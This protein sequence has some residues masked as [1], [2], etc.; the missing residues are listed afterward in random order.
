MLTLMIVSLLMVIVLSF[1][2]TVR[3]SLR[4][5]AL[6]MDRKMA[7][8]NARLGAELAMARLQEMMGA[9]TR[10]SAAA[11]QFRSD[12]NSVYQPG[13]SRHTGAK[14]WTG[15]W[16]SLSFTEND[17]R[18]KTFLG[19]L[20]SDPDPA[21]LEDVTV[22]ASDPGSLMM[23]GP[24]SVSREEDEVYVRAVPVQGTATDQY[25]YWV[26]DEGVKAR[27]NL[28][29]PFRGTTDFTERQY[30]MRAAQRH[31][32]ELFTY[33]P[34]GLL[35]LSQ[36]GWY[37]LDNE[38]FADMRERMAGAAQLPLLGWSPESRDAFRS[39][40]GLRFHDVSLVSKGL[41]TNTARGGLRKDLSLAF[42]MPIEEFLAH[43]T[44][45]SASP[46]S[47][48]PVY[49]PPGF[50]ASEQ[51]TPLFRITDFSSFGFDPENSPTGA[52]QNPP[53]N[54]APVLRGPSWQILRNYHRSYKQSDPDRARYDLD[55]VSYRNIGGRLVAQGRSL[56]PNPETLGWMRRYGQDASVWTHAE[57]FGPNTGPKYTT[58]R[59]LEQPIHPGVSPLVTRVQIVFSVRTEPEIV[60]G[61]PTGNFVADVYM[62]PLVTIWNPYNVPLATGE[63]Y[64]QPLQLS[65][66]F[67]DLFMVMQVQGGTTEYKRLKNLFEDATG[68]TGAYDGNAHEAFQLTLDQPGGLVLE[69]GEVVIFSGVDQEVRYQRNAGTL[70]HTD[71]SGVN[72]DLRPDIT[73]NLNTNSGIRFENPWGISLL[74]DARI[75]FRT[76]NVYDPGVPGRDP[77]WT[78][79]IQVAGVNRT[80]IVQEPF[81]GSFD[82][83][84]VVMSTPFS[85]Y[86]PVQDSSI[87]GVKRPF[88]LYDA[89]L[90]AENS[91]NPVNL[92][93]Q[94]NL[95]S[96]SMEQG[97]TTNMESNWFAPAMRV[98]DLWGGQPAQV[99]GWNGLF[100]QYV[101]NDGRSSYW[102]GASNAAGGSKRVTLFEL[103]R[104]PPMSI[105]SL[106]HAQVTF[107]VDEPSLAIGNSLVPFMV[108]PDEK[109]SLQQLNT[110]S[111]GNVNTAY[112]NLMLRWKDARTPIRD[113]WTMT[114]TDWSY[115]LNEVLWDDY[116]FSSLTPDPSTGAETWERYDAFVAGNP[117]P[118][119]TLQPFK[120]PGENMADVRARLFSGTDIRRNA[121]ERFAANLIQEGTFNVNSTS[122]EAWRA[123]LSSTRNLILNLQDQS[124][125]REL[126]GTA[127]S[128]TALPFDAENDRWHGFRNLSDAQIDAL[129]KEIVDQVRIRGPFLNLSDFINRRLDPSPHATQRSGALQSAIDALDLNQSFTRSLQDGGL[130]LS[131]LN[132]WVRDRVDLDSMVAQN[133][134]GYFQQAD[135]LTL[136]GPILSARSDTFTVRAY[137][138]HA[139]AKAWCELT[140]QR[141]PGYVDD[142]NQPWDAV[143]GLTAVNQAFGRR[144]EVTSFRWLNKEDL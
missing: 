101:S 65:F 129:A 106:Q 55:P 27:F 142:S 87:N 104:L 127:F 11:D 37:P 86:Y 35:P 62:D 18:N 2:V 97:N 117:L 9:D 100:S 141:L 31:A 63:N 118:N 56:Y 108:R 40:L 42:E 39:M 51:I 38:V 144:F 143:S 137:G 76:M 30:S 19:W 110:R 139:G 125:P 10:V 24:G 130:Q 128:R 95:R 25:G 54:L 91:E 23:V 122:V 90:K 123:V 93:S 126:T 107:M 58:S 72:L 44:F 43:P 20:V 84:N 83:S 50:P 135:L 22:I 53:K 136:I 119:S 46:D 99:N 120:N 98:G 4:E 111:S 133:A 134:P 73:A 66:R 75:S 7:Q 71:Y 124:Q 34:A 92:M 13:L 57:L 89:F 21:R 1:V 69:P 36:S 12:G 15:A 32:A 115:M 112:P 113:D 116:F 6:T 105:A 70:M 3:L 81:F 29:D 16:D 114:R 47:E 74:P 96:P 88:F 14:N 5:T 82:A 85:A 79:K 78:Q 41:M 138:D 132:S 52:S 102:G 140:V 80:S 26:G 64:G 94:F 121:P 33:D 28:Q 77:N 68:N 109:L 131:H 103:P 59:P 48:D 60:A 8:S 61:L 67:I 45:G 17:A 49:Q